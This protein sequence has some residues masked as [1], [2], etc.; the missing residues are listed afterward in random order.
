MFAGYIM[1]PGKE[2]DDISFENS[3]LSFFLCQEVQLPCNL[4]IHANV[5]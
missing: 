5:R 1:V 4:K 2:G 3:V